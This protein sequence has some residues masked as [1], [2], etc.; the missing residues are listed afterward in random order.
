MGKEYS[1]YLIYSYY[2]RVG[3]EVEAQQERLVWAQ[4]L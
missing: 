3:S 2:W 4:N 1:T